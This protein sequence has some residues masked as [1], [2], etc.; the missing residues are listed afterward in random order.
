MYLTCTTGR[1]RGRCGRRNKIHRGGGPA[2]V[3]A[4]VPDGGIGQPAGAG[5]DAAIDGRG[6]HAHSLREAIRMLQV[7]LGRNDPPLPPATLHAAHDLVFAVQQ[8]LMAA[9]PKHPR[10]KRHRGRAEGQPTVTRVYDGGL[11]KVLTVP[12]AP[13]GSADD[14]WLDLVDATVER[15]LD[16]W[17]YA[18]QHALRAARSRHQPR[19]AL[20]GVPIASGDYW[21]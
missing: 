7:R 16:R 18:Q 9:N 20:P 2:G 11:W 10:P 14:E 12:T 8:R 6:R 4:Q 1:L 5:R 21:E 15:A 19:T 13:N 3:A 17:C